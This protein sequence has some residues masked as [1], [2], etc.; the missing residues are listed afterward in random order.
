VTVNSVNDAPTISNIANQTINEDGN[1]GN[2]AF[3][4]GDV[5]TLTSS[6]T[7]TATSSNTT[8]VP[9]S[10]STLTLGGSGGSRT[11]KV[12]PAANKY[13]TATITVTTSD[14]T[15]ST[16]D[17]FVVTVNSV[18]DPPT[19][20]GIANVTLND[21]AST[22]AISFT[23]GDVETAANLLTVT[24]SSSN[25]TLIPAGNLTLGGSGANRTINVS[26]RPYGG[27]G[28]STITV[29]V[30]DGQTSRNETFVVTV[31]DIPAQLTVP[32]TDSDG[33]GSYTITWL[34]VENVVRVWEKAPG[35]SWVNL[36][37]TS[38][39]SVDGPYGEKTVTH[40]QNGTYEYSL[41]DCH[42]EW[43][44]QWHNAAMHGDRH[45]FGCGQRGKQF[46][47]DFQHRQCRGQRRC[48]K[49]TDCL[50]RQ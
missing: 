23:V 34:G 3:T 43:L 18:N 29:T 13:G 15:L 20:S 2:I 47:G 5:E 24:A 42:Y 6:L 27:A 31:N 25:T 35:G 17:I 30:S 36:S 45:R 40:I 12:T 1:T 38:S 46:A 9:N 28:T 19:I 21:G 7:V 26:A 33:D 16:S 44:R 22:G 32:A 41:E 4:I 11:I 8:L 14:G 48:V 37:A 49:R 39:S 50:Y 10:S